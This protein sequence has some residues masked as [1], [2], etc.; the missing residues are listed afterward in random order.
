MNKGTTYFTKPIE[1]PLVIEDDLYHNEMICF[2]LYLTAEILGNNKKKTDEE[3]N[4]IRAF[5]II[6]NIMSCFKSINQASNFIKHR[7]TFKELDKNEEMTVIDYYNYHYDVV[8]DPG[9]GGSDIGTSNGII[10]EKDVNLR[11]SKYKRGYC[12]IK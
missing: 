2:V 8:I 6:T 12:L 7:P 3:L 10:A 5:N 1:I 9:H 4:L 11:V